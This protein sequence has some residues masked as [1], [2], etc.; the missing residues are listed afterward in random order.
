M[1]EHNDLGFKGEAEAE[2]YLWANGYTVLKTNFKFDKAEIDIIAQKD[3]LI[4]V[5]EVKTRTGTQFGFPEEFVSAKKEELIFT[6]TE[7]FLEQNSID[8]PVRFDVI[9]IVQ[10]KS[11]GTNLEHF[12]DAFR[13]N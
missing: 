8:L 10:T 12:K 7:A 6:A 3:D 1:A 11:N 4:V 2:K 13:A 5:V 9:A